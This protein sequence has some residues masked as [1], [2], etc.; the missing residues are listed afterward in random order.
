MN[1]VIGT[2]AFENERFIA[3]LPL[4]PF[5][6]TFSYALLMLVLMLSHKGAVRCAH[7]IISRPFRRE[8]FRDGEGGPVLPRRTLLTQ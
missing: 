1:L 3:R 7:G 5:L 2:L 6:K 8:P 4:N